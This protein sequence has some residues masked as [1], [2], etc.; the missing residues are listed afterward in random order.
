M[1]EFS[2]EIG[3][4]T[5]R[6]VLDQGMVWNSFSWW[7]EPYY[8]AVTRDA[9]RNLIN[10]ARSASQSLSLFQEIE[11]LYERIRLIHKK[12]EGM[13]VDIPLSSMDVLDFLKDEAKLDR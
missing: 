12:E 13:T 10:E 11:W 2:E 8:L 4:M 3:Y 6:K 1:L 7:L 5:R 9:G